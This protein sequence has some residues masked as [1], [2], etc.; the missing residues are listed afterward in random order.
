MKKENQC[1][2]CDYFKNHQMLLNYYE[3]TGFCVCPS[4]N[5]NTTEGRRI[6]VVDLEN[7]KN[8]SKVSG[9]PS[10]DFESATFPSITQSQYL[11]QVDDSFG[12]VFY[13]PK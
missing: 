9:N 10:H 3:K 4:G 8:R 1:K 2:T 6:G 11:L 7:L 12:C 5:F 13:R